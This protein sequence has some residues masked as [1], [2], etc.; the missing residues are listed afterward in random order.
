MTRQLTVRGVPDEVGLRLDTISRAK[1][2]SVNRLVL[3]ILEAAVS[4]DER[5]ERLKRYVTWT[6]QDLREFEEILETQR[7]IDDELWS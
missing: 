7:K 2:K 5:R 6:E 1:G 4:V 3:E